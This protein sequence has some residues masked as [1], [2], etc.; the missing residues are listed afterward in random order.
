MLSLIAV[1]LA[2]AT[3]GAAA[4]ARTDAALPRGLAGWNARGAS[5]DSGKAVS[6][7]AVDPASVTLVGVPK[8][9]KPGNALAASFMVRTAGTYGIAIGSRGWIDVY[10]A[11]GGR[12]ALTSSTHGHGPACSTIAKIVRY[13]LQPGAYRVLVSGVEGR[14]EKLMLVKGD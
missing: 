6:M 5:L 8:P 11:V 14:T 13:R 9:S 2:Q 3:P 7:P 4:C 10:P 12:T 1:L